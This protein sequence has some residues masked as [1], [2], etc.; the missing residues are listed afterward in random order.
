MNFSANLPHRYPHLLISK[1]CKYG[2]EV[3][4]I[5]LDLLPLQAYMPR[6][7][8]GE[9]GSDKCDASALLNLLN[10]CDHFSYIDQER[11]RKVTHPHTHNYDLFFSFLL[12]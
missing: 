4:V 3:Y 2:I 7:Q 5:S 1:K 6:G 11:V 9:K 10:Y 12:F 8:T